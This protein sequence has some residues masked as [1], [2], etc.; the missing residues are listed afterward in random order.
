MSEPAI[1][2]Q[3]VDESVYVRRVLGLHPGLSLVPNA[4][5]GV[6]QWVVVERDACGSAA[7]LVWRKRVTVVSAG[8]RRVM[9]AGRN[10]DSKAV[11]EVWED[12]I[13]LAEGSYSSQDDLA[14]AMRKTYDHIGAAEFAD[15]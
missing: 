15:D 9:V 7:M 14:E 4:D 5:L 11:I 1:T 6:K 3:P 12:R 13:K 8:P 10:R 2:V